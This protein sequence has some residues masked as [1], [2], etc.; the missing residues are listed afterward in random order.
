[1]DRSPGV[2]RYESSPPTPPGVFRE[3]KYALVRKQ[4][5]L[6]RPVSARAALIPIRKTSAWWA[7][8][9]DEGREIFEAQSHHIEIGLK[10]LPA[11]ARRLHHCR[12]L[13]TEQP[14]EFITWFEY[15][16]P[17]SVAFDDL[18]GAVRA[19]PEWKYVDRDIDI[20]LAR[21]EI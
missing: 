5:G 12:D 14:F 18:V 21:A 11:V 4:Q 2:G 17:D 20:R 19:S 16:P 9:Q 13:G 15:A 6:V 3:E 10:Y 7:L 1:M 8:S